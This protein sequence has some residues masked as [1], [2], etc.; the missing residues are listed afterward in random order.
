MLFRRDRLVA[1]WQATLPECLEIHIIQYVHKSLELAG[2]DKCAWEINQ[3]FRLKNVGRK[4]P[5]LIASCDICERFKHPNSSL[6]IEEKGH[7]PNKPR[8][9]CSIDLYGPLP[10]GR[11]G[12]R[13]ILVC[14]KVFSKYV[15]LYPLKIATAMPCLNKLINHY[16]LEV[17]KPK[18]IISDIGTQFQSPLWKESMRKRDVQVR[19]SAIRHPQS[20]PSERCM[21]ESSKFCRIYFHSNHRKRA[22][23]IPHIENW[24]NNTVASTSLYTPVKLL[25]GAER[26]NLFQK[27]LPNLPKG[28]MKHKEMQEKIAKA[29]EGMKQR[30]H[31][32]KVRESR[33]M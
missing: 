25:F 14:F 30:T 32:G 26:N 11:G 31:D 2:V 3:S 7:V 9:L 20:N 12:V 4:V 13:H 17:V 5:G 19:Y 18:V 1:I 33:K 28:E 8:E 22:E 27:C 29:Y 6:D 10:T 24:L 23:L 16:F 21:R 15:N